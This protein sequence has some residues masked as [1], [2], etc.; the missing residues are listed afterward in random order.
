[1][2][3]RRVEPGT[4]WNWNSEVWSQRPD[5]VRRRPDLLAMALVIATL[6]ACG[7]DVPPEADRDVA[8]EVPQPAAEPCGADVEPSQLTETLSRADAPDAERMVACFRLRKLGVTSERALEGLQ[9]CA[10]EG[11]LPLQREAIR[12]L[13]E[14]FPDRIE[15]H[16]LFAKLLREGDEDMQGFA[17]LQARGLK[18]RSEDLVDA[19]LDRLDQR[20]AGRVAT[21]INA[22][23]ALEVRSDRLKL[24]L[25]DLYAR[26]EFVVR[27]A[28]VDAMQSLFADTVEAREILGAAATDPSE[29]VR[30][31]ASE[32]R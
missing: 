21:V 29:Y 32:P 26:D 18:R 15:V 23:Q 13:V 25:V 12:T 7:A 4:D 10:A 16:R 8:S 3:G 14:N 30:A 28:V 5:S 9:T 2:Y 19:L 11:S 31:A 22:L 6:C 20:R 17:V 24:Q 27:V 1:M